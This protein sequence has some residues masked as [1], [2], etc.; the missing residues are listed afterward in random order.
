MSVTYEDNNNKEFTNSSHVEGR[1]KPTATTLH[2]YFLCSCFS[3]NKC[4]D[5][6]CGLLNAQL[7]KRE[8]ILCDSA[9]CKIKLKLNKAITRTFTNGHVKTLDN[10]II[11]IL[12]TCTAHCTLWRWAYFLFKSQIWMVDIYFLLF[13]S[14]EIFNMSATA[15]YLSQPCGSLWKGMYALYLYILPPPPPLPSHLIQHLGDEV[16][17]K[18][19]IMMIIINI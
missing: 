5:E 10:H 7:I 3:Y 11:A 4:Y 2:Q 14:G 17:N 12:Y 6:A 15:G 19:I 8:N 1:R 18:L 9:I 13:F 16:K